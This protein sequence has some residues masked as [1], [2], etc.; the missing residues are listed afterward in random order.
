M[1]SRKD[2]KGYN[3]IGIFKGILKMDPLDIVR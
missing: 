1:L 2:T 3:I